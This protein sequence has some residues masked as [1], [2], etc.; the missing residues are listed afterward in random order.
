[1]CRCV[2]QGGVPRG[3]AAGGHQA[4]DVLWGREAAQPTVQ[5]LGGQAETTGTGEK[6]DAEREE[7]VILSARLRECSWVLKRHGLEW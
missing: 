4:V 5:Q 3:A 6:I 7:G 2:G 1:V